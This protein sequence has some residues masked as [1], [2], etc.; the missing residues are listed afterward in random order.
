[1]M[2]DGTKKIELPPTAGALLSKP[3]PATQAGCAG[4]GWKMLETDAGLVECTELYARPNTCRKSTYG[5][6]KLSR[7]WILKYSRSR[8]MTGR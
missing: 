7:V 1:M 2:A 6:Q 4:A 8:S 3:C 5:E